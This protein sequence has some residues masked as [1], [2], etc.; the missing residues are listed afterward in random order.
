MH[1]LDQYDQSIKWYQQAEELAPN[2]AS[3]LYNMGLVYF[4]TGDFEESRGYA[5]RA[6]ELGIEFPALRRK[7]QEAGHWD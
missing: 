1:R 5:I 6:Y 4:D 2:D 7:L 3:L